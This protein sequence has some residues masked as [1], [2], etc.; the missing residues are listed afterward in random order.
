MDR[1]KQMSLAIVIK[2]LNDK[3]E[4]TLTNNPTHLVIIT[5]LVSSGWV[6]ILP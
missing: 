4:K 3:D 5:T 1:D 6:T 2:R